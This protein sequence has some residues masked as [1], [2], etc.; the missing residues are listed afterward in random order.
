MTLMY[1]TAKSLLFRPEIQ[2]AAMLDDVAGKMAFFHLVESDR[3]N[4]RQL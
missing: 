3:L 1:G 4:K 2:T